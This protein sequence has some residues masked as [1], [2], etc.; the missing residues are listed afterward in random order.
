MV[1]V[2]RQVGTVASGSECKG[3]DRVI[4]PTEDVFASEGD[5]VTL[6]C[7]FETTRTSPTLIWYRQKCNDFPRYIP[8]F[9]LYITEGGSIH[10]TDSDFSAYI[11]KTEKRVNL[12]ISSAALTDSA[13]YYCAL[14]PQ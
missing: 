1:A 14:S 11:N 13:V 10:P 4:Q 6:D 2:F 3:E 12:E 8:E 5:T 9:L 7:I